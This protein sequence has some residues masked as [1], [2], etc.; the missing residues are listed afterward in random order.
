PDP[1]A[2]QGFMNQMQWAAG[3]LGYGQPQGWDP[4][5]GGAGGY[6]GMGGPGMG[7]IPGMGG[8]GGP[9]GAPQGAALGPSGNIVWTSGTAN[10]TASGDP[11]QNDIWS[12]DV[13]I[14]V[15]SMSA[16]VTSQITTDTQTQPNEQVLKITVH[17]PATGVDTVY[18]VHDY[19]DA[20]IKINSP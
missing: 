7:G 19:S 10:I 5:Q 18:L 15:P 1:N 11:R 3:Q 4:S 12:N 8:P 13:T 17:D 20:K 2:W 6:P 16:S 9:Q 14:N